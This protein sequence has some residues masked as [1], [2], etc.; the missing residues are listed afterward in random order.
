[1]YL[2]EKVVARIERAVEQGSAVDQALKSSP[3]AIFSDDWVDLG[4]QLMPRDRLQLLSQGIESGRLPDV[5]AVYRELAHIH[6]QYC[7]DEW[8]WVKWALKKVLDV[9]LDQPTSAQIAQ[10]IDQWQTARKDFLDAVLV[11]ATKEFDRHSRIGFGTD[12]VEDQAD[13]DFQ[14]V[15]GDYDSNKFVL[16]MREEIEQLVSRAEKLK[17]RLTH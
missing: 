15:R 2:A 10:V 6:E 3:N 8:L 5:E 9:D 12:G 17:E 4:G 14:A 7:E 1:M 16:Q 13:Q 11:D